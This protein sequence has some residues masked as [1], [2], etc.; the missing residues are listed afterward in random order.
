MASGSAA[1]L[2]PPP[3]VSNCFRLAVLPSHSALTV[4]ALRFTDSLHTPSL[5]SLSLAAPSAPAWREGV[6][7]SI[8]ADSRLLRIGVLCIKRGMEQIRSADN[9]VTQSWVWLKVEKLTSEPTG[10]PLLGCQ[11]KLL[12]RLRSLCPLGR[13][14][15][16]SSVWRFHS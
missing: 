10:L 13:S 9:F 2:L 6:L 7:N 11:P 12:D 3:P 14:A 4:P 15:S 8:S 16:A 5:H 1:V